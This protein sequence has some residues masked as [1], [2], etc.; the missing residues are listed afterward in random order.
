MLIGVVGP[1]AAGKTA[2]LDVCREHGVQVLSSSDMIREEAD[3]RGLPKDRVTLQ[4]VANDLRMRHGPGILAQWCLDRATGDAAVDG[5]RNPGEVEVLRRHGALI[6]GVDAD[7][8]VRFERAMCRQATTGRL[9]NA[10]TF[11]EFIARENAERTADPNG[12]QLHTVFAMADC[13]VMNNGTE[14]ELR[15]KIERLLFSRS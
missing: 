15:R 8:R 12:Q 4:A 7:P 6:I 3:R 2:F 11:E 14:E 5:I 10:T 1:F 13:I 9:E